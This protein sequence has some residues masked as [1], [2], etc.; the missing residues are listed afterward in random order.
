MVDS[1]TNWIKIKPAELKKL[2]IDLHKEGNTPSKIGLILR[3]KHGIPKSKLLGKKI[4][5]ILDEENITYSTDKIVLENKVKNLES[6]IKKNKH[7]YSAKRSLT[8]T[9]WAIKKQN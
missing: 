4:T 8:K 2:V 6:H 9:L 3:D 7:D 1:K 5:H